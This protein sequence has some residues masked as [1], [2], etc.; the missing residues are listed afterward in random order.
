MIILRFLI[1]GKCEKRCKISCFSLVSHCYWW[2]KWPNLFFIH[3]FI[4]FM[5]FF[6]IL[7]HMMR[8][9]PVSNI[10]LS[11]KY[12]SSD[13]LKKIS[14]VYPNYHSFNQIKRIKIN[15]QNFS[16]I[17]LF[18]VNVNRSSCSVNKKHRMSLWYVFNT[19]WNLIDLILIT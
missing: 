14:L 18:T 10:T 17:F 2:L 13:L 8:I 9:L 7:V 11:K 5:D 1:E 6:V 4:T 15:K 19:H 16:F 12:I 3:C